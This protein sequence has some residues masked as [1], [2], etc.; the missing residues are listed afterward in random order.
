MKKYALPI[1]A[2]GFFFCSMQA[3]NLNLVRLVTQ[4]D[5]SGNAR[6][7]AMSG[8]FGGLGGNLSSLHIN[9]AGA[10]VFST[11]KFG[12]TYGLLSNEN[13]STYFGT[14]TP[15]ENRMGGVSQIGSVLVLKNNNEGSWKKIALG[16]NAQR[17]TS[18]DNIVNI[19]GEN[20]NNGLDSYFLNYA[21]GKDGSA[22]GLSE[23]ETVREIYQF[24][25]ESPNYGF[26]YQQAFLGF[27][28]YVFDYIAD[29]G[30]FI[31]NAAY[32]SVNHNHQ[33]I[34][35]GDNWTMAF[36]LSGQYNDW[37]YLGA[38]LNIGSI[39]LNQTTSTFEDGYAS[40]SPIRRI[41]F[42]NEL[43]TYGSGA[44]LQFGAIATPNPSLRVGLSYKS[45]TWY[46]LKDELSQ[47]LET[48]Y[49]DPDNGNRNPILDIKNIVNVYEDYDVKTPS[50]IRGS[51]AYIFGK[52]GLL[53]LDYVYKDYQNSHIGPNDNAVFIDLNNQI[54][55]NWA[56]TSS[57]RIG[58]ELRRNGVIFRGGYHLDQSPYKNTSIESDRSGYT[59]GVGFNFRA[60][61]I[62]I[63][64]LKSNQEGSHQLY[65]TGLTDRA[66]ISSNYGRFNISWNFK[67]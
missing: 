46:S 4:E 16:F 6:F 49:A 51:V 19:N 42:D 15:T 57:Y 61:T 55:K 35:K 45:P 32:S 5:L 64:F 34:T 56:S 3:Q 2:I 37:L 66:Q 10:A 17:Q 24:F 67:F 7:E 14:T 28:G 58:G 25:G 43:Y 50:E 36:T 53:S 26:E 59:Y 39:E 22:L 18:Y 54:N 13:E 9:P 63:S 47:Y 30:L 27:Q 65:D 60:S 48:N 52:H 33:Y 8:A 40:D 23:V 31:S 41:Y 21:D 1:V 29:D 38:N 44:S 12:M 11:N 62:D 20:S